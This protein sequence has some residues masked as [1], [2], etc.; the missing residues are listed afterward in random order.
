MSFS[1]EAVS[2]SSLNN[3]TP[4][5]PGLN[6]RYQ[7]S[8]DMVARL[9]SDQ[10]FLVPIRQRI[11][12]LDSVFGLTGS[13]ARIWDLVDGQRSLQDILDQVI[14]EFEVARDQ[15]AEDLLDLAEQ[16]LEIGALERV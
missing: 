9:I 15:A 5:Q 3:G 10:V 16:L 8:R 1:Q 4:R 6:D 14:A 11:G 13:A 2:N 12:D 7:K